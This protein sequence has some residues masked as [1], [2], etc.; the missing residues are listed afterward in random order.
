MIVI[1]S[2]CVSVV[3][4]FEKEKLIIWPKV[5]KKEM[6]K[7][8][9]QRNNKMLFIEKWAGCLSIRLADCLKLKQ[10]NNMN[11]KPECK[12]NNSFVAYNDVSDELN[13]HPPLAVPRNLATISNHNFALV[14]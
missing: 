14:S 9:I 8:D 3:V 7:A 12:N 10:K 6:N 2:A 5:P 11:H 1:A 13:F 4:C